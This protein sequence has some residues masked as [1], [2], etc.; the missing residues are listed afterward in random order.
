MTTRHEIPTHLAVEDRPLAG[1]TMPQLL[2]LLVGGCAGYL[3]WQGAAFLPTS[4]RLAVVGAALVVGAA[5]ALFRPHGQSLLAWALVVL[6]YL[7]LPRV[8][9]WRAGATPSGAEPGQGMLPL[10]PV[11]A[12]A[13]GRSVLSTAKAAAR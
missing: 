3:T 10:A 8:C 2:V 5:A 6:R 4:V 13:A 1:L 11:L 7:A 12:W 9:L